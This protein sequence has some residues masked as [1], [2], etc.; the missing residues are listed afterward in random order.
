MNAFRGFRSRNP[1]SLVPGILRRVVAG[2]CFV[3]FLLLLFFF[4]FFFF[5]LGGGGIICFVLLGFSFVFCFCSRFVLFFV[6]L[7]FFLLHLRI[8]AHWYQMILLRDRSRKLFGFFLCVFFSPLGTQAEA[9][10]LWS[11]A[12][13]KIRHETDLVSPLLLYQFIKQLTWICT[14]P[15]LR[16]FA[17]RYKVIWITK[18]PQV[19]DHI[20]CFSTVG[21]NP[22]LE[23]GANRTR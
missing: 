11:Q 21:P 14:I 12:D 6:C 17:K 2:F 22:E 23:H 10:P 18:E 20:C 13:W 8:K 3:L 9:G 7:V 19:I 1:K 4:F 5:F 15:H 16:H